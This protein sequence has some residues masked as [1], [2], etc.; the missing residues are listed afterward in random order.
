[1]G[2]SSKIRIGIVL[3]CSVILVAAGLMWYTSPTSD[4]SARSVAEAFVAKHANSDSV[5][6][7]ESVIKPDGRVVT[8][9]YSIPRAQAVSVEPHNVIQV[10]THS[11]GLAVKGW[12]RLESIA[13]DFES[14]SGMMTIRHRV[15]L[16]KARG[17]GEWVKNPADSRPRWHVDETQ[18]D[19]DWADSRLD[20]LLRI[21]ENLA[22]ADLLAE[23]AT[24]SQAP[25][26]PNSRLT[27]IPPYDN[28]DTELPAAYFAI[29]LNI[30]RRLEM[31]NELIELLYELSEYTHSGDWRSDE[32]FE[33][34]RL[35]MDFLVQEGVTTLDRIEE[36][37]AQSSSE[38]LFLLDFGDEQAS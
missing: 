35:A 24:M 3:S 16:G 5:R 10:N 27:P 7:V 22:P 13:T 17:K 38:L 9:E 34:A 21:R 26:G 12:R 31:R 1:M 6:T 37:F 20:E 28:K 11:D 4:A 14:P 30:A 19:L 25:D 2:A 8:I 29:D 18:L 33:E 32:C 36:L 15:R 23:V